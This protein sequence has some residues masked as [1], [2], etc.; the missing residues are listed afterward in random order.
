[1]Y[2]H[3]PHSFMAYY[4]NNSRNANRVLTENISGVVYW[5][6]RVLRKKWFL[7]REILM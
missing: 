3:S 6:L 2:F 7:K 5:G 1:M 4:L